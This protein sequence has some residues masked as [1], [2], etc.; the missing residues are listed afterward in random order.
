MRT[1]RIRLLWHKQAQ[2]AGYLLAEK[3]QLARKAG[4]EIVCEGL[5]FSCKHVA[6]ILTGQ[7]EMAVASPAHLLESADPE[8]LR[9]LMTIQQKSPLVYPARRSDGVSNL[10]DLRGRK[11][12]VWPGGEDLE[13]RW[14]LHRAGIADADV[15]RVEIPD[16]VTP[17]LDGETASGQMTVYHELHSV[18][19]RIP[20]DDLVLFDAATFD[21]SILKDGL[22]ADADLCRDAPEL[23]QAVVD[24]VLEGW[25]IAI[26]DPE[27]ALDA[28][29][30]ARPDMPRAAQANQLRQILDLSLIG[31][32]RTHGLG[33][34]DPAHIDRA[35]QAMRDIEGHAPET[36]PLRDTRFWDTAPEQFRRTEWP[37]ERCK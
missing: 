10:A 15:E 27:R 18:E 33:H 19:D 6:S 20:A 25:T 22:V 35:A 24:G 23:V 1:V 16:T 11:V 8:R 3:L 36:G 12:G 7:A 14:M 2:F 4:V 9:W 13:F 31:A 30:E 29:C 37:V 21:C 26:E 28:C 5:D 34:P 32:T 17:F